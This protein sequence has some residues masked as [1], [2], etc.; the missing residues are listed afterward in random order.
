MILGFFILYL[1]KKIICHP[2]QSEGS[3]K[4][5]LYSVEDASLRYR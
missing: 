1:D 5:D 4:S 3:S 2:E